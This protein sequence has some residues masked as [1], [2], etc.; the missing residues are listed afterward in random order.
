MKKN[1]IFFQLLIVSFALAIS[2]TGCKKDNGGNS[3]TSYVKGKMDGVAFECGS[4]ITANTPEPITG[5]ADPTIRITGNWLN[6][7]IK[8]MLISETASI[9]PGIYTF[10]ADKN[11]S[12]TIWIGSDAYYAGPSGPFLPPALKGSGSITLSEVSKN[13]VRGTFQFTSEP[14]VGITKTVTDGEF[15]INRN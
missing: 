4:G 12:A 1:L 6:N 13:Y 5:P 11:R 8:L 15:Y 2:F 3:F 7:S 14:N 10:Q 9:A